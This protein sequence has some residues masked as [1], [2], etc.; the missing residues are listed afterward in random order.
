MYTTSFVSGASLNSG[1][2]SPSY[3]LPLRIL[4]VLDWDPSLFMS[5]SANHKS[6]GFEHFVLHIFI[7]A[8]DAMQVEEVGLV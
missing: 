2:V 4:R 8:T 7:V 6:P 5:V 3:H 1:C